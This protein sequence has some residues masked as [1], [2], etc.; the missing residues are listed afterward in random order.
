MLEIS[1]Y[2]EWFFNGVEGAELPLIMA[3]AYP[4]SYHPHMAGDHNVDKNRHSFEIELGATEKIVVNTFKEMVTVKMVNT[5]SANFGTSMGL[6][7]SYRTGKMLARDGTTIIEDANEFGQEWQVR[8]TEDILFN[9][10]R[11]P[12]YPQ[13]CVPQS[14]KAVGR[15]LGESITEEEARV[16]CSHWE[17]HKELC[18]YDVMS[19]G[20]LELAQAGA[21]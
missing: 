13:Q 16:A 21:F 4:V 20:D 3:E 6:M 17:E 5:T 7:G 12:Q 1:S 19:T 15:R 9:S 14:A 8:E 2:A 10:I 18:I 11:A